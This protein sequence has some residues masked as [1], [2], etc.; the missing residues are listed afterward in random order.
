MDK[1]LNGQKSS[2]VFSNYQ[3]ESRYSSNK[4]KK[5]NFTSGFLDEF[6]EELYPSKTKYDDKSEKTRKK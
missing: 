4:Q 5:V 6:G 1:S 3:N 2:K